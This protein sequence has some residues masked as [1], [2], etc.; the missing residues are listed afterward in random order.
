M[1]NIPAEGTAA[2]NALAAAAL[3][4]PLT[5]VVVSAVLK[6]KVLAFL[7]G[8]TASVLILAAAIAFAVD[9]APQ[10]GTWDAALIFGGSAFIVSLGG[11]AFIAGGRAFLASSAVN[12]GSGTAVVGSTASA[13]DAPDDASA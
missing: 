8:M 6:S 13:V 10:D 1:S 5:A 7:A 2:G 9:A 4:A 11:T 12:T 3:L